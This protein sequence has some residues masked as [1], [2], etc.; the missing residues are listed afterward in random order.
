MGELAAAVEEGN[1]MNPD[2]ITR[3]EALGRSESISTQS[4]RVLVDL[5][6][7][8]ADGAALANSDQNFISTSTARF[9]SNTETDTWIDVIADEVIS[10]VLDGEPLD[11]HSYADGRLPLHVTEGDHELSVTARMRY[12]RT[13][14][15]LHRFVDPAD[16]KI[17]LYS[18][19]ETA[20]ARR[21]YACF[22]QPNL[23]AHF[24][25][26]VLAPEHWKV[27]SNSPTPAAQPF[28]GGMARW[29]FA[30]TQPISTY[31][32]A[33]VA[34]DFFVD[35]GVIESRKG[36]LP[37]GV[38]C[39]QSMAEHFDPERIRQTAQRGFEVYEEAFGHE[40]PFDKYDQIFVPEFNAGAMENAGCVTFRDSYV[41]R[42]QTTEDV[43]DARDNTI[44]HELAH[45]WFGDLVTMKWWDDLWLNE[46]FAEWSAYF[47]QSR[48]TETYGGRNAWTTF[49]SSRK[50]WAYNADQL[51]TTHPIAAD[52]IDLETVDQSFDGITYA[53]GASVLKQ[54][55]AYVGEENF[56]RGVDDHLTR[57][58]WAN[59]EFADLLDALQRAS[60]RDL[61]EFSGQ[62]L[63]TTGVNTVRTEIDV[64]DA[65]VIT[66]FE[67]VQSGE[68]LRTHLLAIGLYDFDESGQLV[69]QESLPVDVHGER[70]PIAVLTGRQRPALI[71]LNDRDLDFVKVRLDEQS[72]QVA[73]QHLADMPDPLARAMVWSTANDCLR[74]AELPSR[75]FLELILSGLRTEDYISTLRHQLMQA[76]QAATAFTSQEHRAARRAQLVG[77]LTE[78]LLAAEPGSDRQL[79]LANALIAAIDSPA[80]AELLKGWLAGEEIPE[81]LPIDADRRWTILT[82]LARLGAVQTSDIDAEAERDQTITGQ[83]AALGARA[84]LADEAA[85]AEAWRLLSEDPDLPNHSYGAI[86]SNFWL[87]SQR[88]LTADYRPRFLE[89]VEQMAASEGVW[90]KRGHAV[91]QLALL[92]L[93]PN[94]VVDQAYLDEVTAWNQAHP[95]VPAQITKNLLDRVDTSARALRAQALDAQQ[96]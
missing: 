50:A 14:E 10:A 22:E 55:V 76:Q 36:T 88:E 62:W 51:P 95:N 15:G 89:M 63:E 75:E 29:D 9:Q 13:G 84:A 2:N 24:E 44:L 59:A 96:G 91:R 11:P 1:C 79:A 90:A 25:L 26:T 61:S 8:A 31:I 53:K 5:T 69:C 48:I 46:S 17:Y 52:M 73:V 16:D 4:Y 19:F 80:G 49:A 3:A 43:Y 21:M 78:H 67:I 30:P 7:Q 38:A 87:W 54:L 60:G 12:S 58:A 92:W 28:G 94:T 18:Q 86:A 74:D 82:A 65:G 6:G 70:T 83:Q 33:L 35:D 34:G 20:D 40:Y 57:H 77:G 39:R 72:K 37:A 47:C 68:P 81:G 42:S 23:K 45:M 27:F 66:R 93:W 64:D 32:T 41:F 71:L 56:L 85:K